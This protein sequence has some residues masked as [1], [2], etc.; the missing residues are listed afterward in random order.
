MV[1]S[2]RKTKHTHNYTTPTSKPT[3]NTH[4]HTQT[5]MLQKLFTKYLKPYYYVKN[6]NGFN[7]ALCQLPHQKNKFLCSLRMLGT[8]PAYFG[9]Q[10]IPGNYSDMEHLASIQNT[11]YIS[12]GKHFFGTIGFMEHLLTIR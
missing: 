3:R 10:V 5:A 4:T 6:Q 8:I 12:I 11:N 7:V 9:E 2:R 1:L